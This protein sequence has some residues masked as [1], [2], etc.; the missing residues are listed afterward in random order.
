MLIGDKYNVKG[1]IVASRKTLLKRMAPSNYIR[2]A[3]L[4]HL[5]N[6]DIL[7]E[8]AIKTIVG[9]GKNIKDIEDYEE[10]MKYPDL[11]IEMLKCYSSSKV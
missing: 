1:L 6:D 8:A 7:K 5:C 10:L 9:S 2:A 4:G 3:I 11:G